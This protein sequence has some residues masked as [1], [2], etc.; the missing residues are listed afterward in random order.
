VLPQT[1]PTLTKCDRQTDR[2]T[3]RKTDQTTAS[4]PQRSFY[5]FC[6]PKQFGCG[7]SLRRGV[8]V[9]NGSWVSSDHSTISCSDH[10]ARVLPTQQVCSPFHHR[11]LL[12]YCHRYTATAT[13]PCHRST[14][15]GPNTD[16]CLSNC[17]PTLKVRS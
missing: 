1:S 15:S 7:R 14:L 6:Q 17:I 13:P 8:G 2:Q 10:L 3:D 11:Q 12:H 5:T 16:P 4:F 9:R